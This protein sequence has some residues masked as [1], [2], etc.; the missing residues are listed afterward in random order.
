MNVCKL[1][2]STFGDINAE[3]TIKVTQ[4]K[5]ARQI[6]AMSA[7]SQYQVMKGCWN[8]NV[9]LAN[10]PGEIQ[11]SQDGTVCEQPSAH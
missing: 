11:P 10:V 7:I 6:A 3:I 4:S 9:L 8:S 5:I 1:Y 2:K